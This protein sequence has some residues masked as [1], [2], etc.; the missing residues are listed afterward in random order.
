[1]RPTLPFPWLL[2]LGLVA[3]SVAAY[4]TLPGQIPQ[5][6]DAAGR[7]A[8]TTA[9]SPASWG[10]LPVLAAAMV[11]LLQGIAHQ[12]P[13]RP[14]WFNYAAKVQLL[15]LPIAW[16]APLITRMQRFLD[17]VGVELVLVMGAVQGMLWHT[18]RGGDGA[19]ALPLILGMS[20]VSTPL[21]LL[22]VSRLSDATEQA[23]RQW[24]E[25]GRPTA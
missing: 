17:L 1:M 21:L 18:A 5:Q 3:F 14:H 11:L 19:L 10:L 9:R 6:L 22:G 15:E 20:V 24:T 23:H 13:A 7:I 2:W 25:R 16:R 8:G 4:P 12:L